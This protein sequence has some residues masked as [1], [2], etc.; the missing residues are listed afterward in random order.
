MVSIQSLHQTVT[1]LEMINDHQ[2]KIVQDL[3]VQDLEKSVTE[4]K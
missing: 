3:I 4:L 1:K 2:S